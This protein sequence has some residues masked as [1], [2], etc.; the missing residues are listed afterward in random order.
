MCVER[1]EEW[2]YAK[3][4][5]IHTMFASY[6]RTSN[7]DVEQNSNNEKLPKWLSLQEQKKF[8]FLN[9]SIE[10]STHNFHIDSYTMA[11]DKY[12]NKWSHRH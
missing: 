4:H 8:F 11:A 12:N 5:E 1:S 3:T 7:T 6:G 2:L 10:F 9:N